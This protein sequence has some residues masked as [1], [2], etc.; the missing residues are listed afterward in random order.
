LTSIERFERAGRALNPGGD[1][2]AAVAKLLNIRRDSVRHLIS[3]R[4]S[5][6]H[7]HFRDLLAAIIEQQKELARAEQELRAWLEQLPPEKS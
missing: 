5:I 2:Q 3:G 7:G 1:W 4:I 6:K